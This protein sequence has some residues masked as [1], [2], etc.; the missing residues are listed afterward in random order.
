LRQAFAW[1]V[2]VLVMVGCSG[3]VVGP[4]DYGHD[5]TI[6]NGTTGFVVL[7]PN[8]RPGTCGEGRR[9]VPSESYTNQILTPVPDKAGHL[10]GSIR[11]QATDEWGGALFCRIYTFDELQGLQWKVVITFD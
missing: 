9:M 2:L 7:V 6:T 10:Q 4:G 11:I 3:I 8:C 5:L 1:L